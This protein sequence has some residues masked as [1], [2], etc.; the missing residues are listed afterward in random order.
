M[1]T[2]D[3]NKRY[4]SSAARESWMRHL[5]FKVRKLGDFNLLAE[6]TQTVRALCCPRLRE[7]LSKHF[8][9]HPA[10]VN[11]VWR[12]PLRQKFRKS[13]LPMPFLIFA[14]VVALYL[15]NSIVILKEY[16]RGVIFRLGRVREAAAGP[17]VI[18]VLRP[19]DTLTESPSARRPWRSPRRTSSPATTSP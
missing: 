11:L 15:L 10:R 9:R 19:I 12:S 16:E 5:F 17:G 3:W 1:A 6:P 14:A 4:L 8:P 2:S 13:G 7:S 18:F